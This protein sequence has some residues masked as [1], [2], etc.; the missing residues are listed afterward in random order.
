MRRNEARPD[1]Q[2]EPRYAKGVFIVARERRQ[3]AILSA[4][5]VLTAVGMVALPAL[6]GVLQKA[7]A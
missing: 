2:V 4:V 1:R 7:L 5:A 3:D 6:L